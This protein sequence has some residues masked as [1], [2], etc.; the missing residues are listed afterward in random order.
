MTNAKNPIIGPINRLGRYAPLTAVM[1][2]LAACASAPKAPPST[3]FDAVVTTAPNINPDPEGRPSPLVMRIYE[4]ASDSVFNTADFFDLYDKETAVLATM[5]VKRDE[6][7][8][9]PLNKLEIKKELQP[10]TRFVG[11]VAAY[12]KIDETA[13]RAVV[14]IAAHKTNRFVIHLEPTG[15]SIKP[16]DKPEPAAKQEHNP[17]EFLSSLLPALSFATDKNNGGVNVPE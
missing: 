14:A 16:I 8:V 10:S 6:L 11:V 2:V 3:R 7:T 5:L 1:L 12:R 9:M 13:W 15:V 17:Q 4:L